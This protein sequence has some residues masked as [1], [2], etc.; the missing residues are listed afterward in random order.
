MPMQRSFPSEV[1]A[2]LGYYVYRLVDPR[3]GDTFYVGKG[4]GDRVFCHVQEAIEAEKQAGRMSEHLSKD[5]RDL[6]SD[7]L[8]D[9]LKFKTI[10]DIQNSGLEVVTIVHR[11]GMS[12]ST[13]FEVE[14]ALI[15]AYPRLTNLVLGHGSQDQGAA[16]LSELMRRYAAVDLE[17]K[18]SLLA[19]SVGIS[20]Q[21]E[22]RELYDAVRYAWVLD[23][24]KAK[25]AELVLAHTGGL[26]KGVFVPENWY[27][28]NDPSL[29]APAGLEE[30]RWGFVGRPADKSIKEL[31]A[32]KR[33]PARYRKK[34]AAN[35][36]R[37]IN[38]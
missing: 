18:H 35:P 16:S 21:R 4:R 31:Y 8:V 15:D 32:G 14:A 38:P 24:K 28:A 37:Y 3:N 29:G 7:T 6:K 36:V 1:S 25:K 5:E 30:N 19:I 13:A 17:P 26:V 20:Y 27:R 11:H 33:I 22:N 2:G 9:N 34:G 12:E 10:Q 23:S